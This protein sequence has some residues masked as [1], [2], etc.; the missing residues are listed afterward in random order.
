[1]TANRPD[2]DFLNHREIRGHQVRAHRAQCR[3]GARLARFTAILGPSK[4]W[5]WEDPHCRDNLAADPKQFW[6]LTLPASPRQE[7][8]LEVERLRTRGDDLGS[9]M[10]EALDRLAPDLPEEPKYLFDVVEVKFSSW[11]RP[12]SVLGPERRSGEFVPDGP[13]LKALDLHRSGDFGDIGRFDEAPEVDQ[14][15]LRWCP[16]AFPTLARIALA[17]RTGSGQVTSRHRVD[18]IDIS[19]L[20]GL[21]DGV[22]RTLIL[23]GQAYPF[24]PDP[25]IP[26]FVPEDHRAPEFGPVDRGPTWAA[27]WGDR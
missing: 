15:D 1:M 23:P 13:L 5:T 2:S 24:G 21:Y 16:G 6:A 18:D 3:C 19:I 22:G 20:T 4:T 11:F 10:A 9:R 26:E 7:L 27:G 12:L 8:A 14:D 17:V 25:G